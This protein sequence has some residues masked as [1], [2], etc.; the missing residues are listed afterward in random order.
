MK[1][2]LLN[3]VI[4]MTGAT[5]GLGKVSA[6]KAASNGATMVILARDKTKSKLL[7][8]DYKRHYPEGLG[9][10]EIIEGNLSSLDS[11]AQACEKIAATYPVIDMI[12]NNAGIMNFEPKKTIDK[13]E[14]TLQVNLLAPLLIFHS[15]FEN[16]KRST[17]GKIIFTS[18]ALHQGTIHFDNLEFEDKFSSF[19]VYRQSK[20]GVILVS[21]VLSKNL[22][23]ENIGIY[24]QHPGMVRT[25][26]GRNAGWFSKM[27]FYFLGSSAEKGSQT[28]SFLIE[29]DKDNLTSGEYYADK[30]IKTTTKESYDLEV[31]EKLITVAN[32]YL[33]QYIKVDSPF[34]KKK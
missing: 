13:I 26:L 15:L 16:L 29:A 4:F 7:I 3:K 30:K 28:L 33:S 34:L 11:V 25:E 19:K 32:T 1:D 6:L 14:E 12:V 5:S 10:I 22:K 21:R 17:H 8:A 27:I 9:R 23:N 24:T 31:G 18:S 2:S 20:L